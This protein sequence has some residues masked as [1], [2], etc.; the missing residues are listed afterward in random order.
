M[1][2]EVRPLPLGLV[3]TPDWHPLPE[4]DIPIRAFLVLHEDGPLLI[5]TGVGVG[6]EFIERQYQPQLA[7]VEGQLAAHGVAMGDVV[8]V[9]NSHLHFDHCGSNRLFAGTPIVVQRAEYE[10]AKAERYTIPDWVQFEGAAYRQIEGDVE[11]ASG[12]RVISTPGHTPGHQSVLVE[13]ARG[14]EAIVGQAAEDF[15][16]YEARVSADAAL[17]RIASFTPRWLHFSHGE[18]LELG[19]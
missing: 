15:A 5:D 2:P 17:T 14:L 11:L 18:S 12:V 16:D 13:S 3:T 19:V 6:S 7:S 8:A 10:A 1:V 4:Q 9:V